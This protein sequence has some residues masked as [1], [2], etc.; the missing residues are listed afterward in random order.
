MNENISDWFKTNK[1][2]INTLKQEFWNNPET[3]YKEYKCCELT[4]DFLL[5]NG[6]TDVKTVALDLAGKNVEKLPNTVIAKWG[7]GK[8]VIGLLGELDAL[9]GLG[10]EA[11]PYYSPKE[12]NGQAVDTAL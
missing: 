7:S 12:G 3:A 2:R 1:E 11:V 4:K 6:F 9:P 5:E 10:Q 8:P